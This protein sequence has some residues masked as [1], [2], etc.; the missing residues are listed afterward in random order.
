MKSESLSRISESSFVIFKYK[1]MRK[2]CAKCLPIAYVVRGEGNVFT[3]VCPSVYPRGGGGGG[4]GRGSQPGVYPRWGVGYPAGGGGGTPPRVTDGV[5]NTPRS[6]CL[7]RS[8]RRTFL[9]SWVF[10]SACYPRIIIAP[11]VSSFP[12]FALIK[13]SSV[14]FNL[15]TPL[16]YWVFNS[17]NFRFL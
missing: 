5:L 9:F 2:L 1:H 7:L 10:A 13:R 16:S 6:V 8:R 11:T 14:V 3:R 4:G 15:L 17:P 12:T